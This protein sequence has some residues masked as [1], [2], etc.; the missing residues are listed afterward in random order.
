MFS[1]EQ[2][3]AGKLVLDSVSGLVSVRHIRTR[4]SWLSPDGVGGF[5]R[6]LGSDWASW[7]WSH[8]F[9]L[10][11]SM[12]TSRVSSKRIEK[13]LDSFQV[14]GR[15]AIVLET[16]VAELWKVIHGLCCVRFL[17]SSAAAIRLRHNASLRSR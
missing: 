17:C 4:D 1:T 7:G 14:Y 9:I 10:C 5:E 3:A 13:R 6:R 15:L 8:R 11:R 2:D 16:F 12:S